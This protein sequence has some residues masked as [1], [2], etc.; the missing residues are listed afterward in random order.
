MFLNYCPLLLLLLFC[1]IRSS[2]TS[3]DVQVVELLPP[4]PPPTPKTK[5]AYCATDVK[6]GERMLTFGGLPESRGVLFEL[7]AGWMEQW[8]VQVEASSAWGGTADWRNYAPDDLLGTPDSPKCAIGEGLWMPEDKGPTP[9]W[10][11]IRYSVPVHAVSI[12]IYEGWNTGSIKKVE[13]AG[14]DS[15]YTVVWEG[16]VID[17]TC[18][19]NFVVTLEPTDVMIDRVRVHTITDTWEGIDAVK[20]VGLTDYLRTTTRTLDA[21]GLS[22]PSTYGGTL[23]ADHLGRV[24]YQWGGRLTLGTLTNVL[25]VY[26]L[27]RGLWSVQHDGVTGEFPQGRE[28][29]RSLLD[30]E[31]QR[32]LLFFGFSEKDDSSIFWE[33]KLDSNEWSRLSTENTAGARTYPAFERIST[34]AFFFGGSTEEGHVLNDLWVFDL[35]TDMFSCLSPVSPGGATPQIDGHVIILHNNTLHTTIN[36]VVPDHSH[37][38]TTTSHVP[39]MPTTVSHAPSTLS[40]VS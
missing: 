22:A 37:V 33:F 14:A 40:P 13:I 4:R 34:Q 38:S 12:V 16:D 18:P 32:I 2:G 31:K 24:L 19:D 29:S 30:E 23:C 9:E 26:D 27:W 3:S 15:E 7:A 28:G 1:C 17:P 21:R 10:F 35:S 8:G 36:S 20:L 39:P 5:F 25:W 11:E 6:F